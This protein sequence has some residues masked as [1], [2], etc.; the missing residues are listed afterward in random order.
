MSERLFQVLEI[1]GPVFALIGLG[2]LLH[3]KKWLTDEACHTINRI[4]ANLSLPALI[5]LVIARTDFAKLLKWPVIVGGLAPILVA[6]L[7]YLP[8]SFL[9]KIKG[10]ER[11]PFLYAPFWGNVSY[12]GIP[13]AIFAFGEAIGG[14]NAAIVNAFTMPFYV[15]I[16]T[17]IIGIHH[18]DKAGSLFAR[19]FGA[20]WNP[21]PLSAVAGI[22]V[23][24]SIGRFSLDSRMP[25]AVTSLVS[26]SA[27]TLELVGKMGLPLALLSI[28]AALR[29]NTSLRRIMVVGVGCFGRLVIAPLVALLA[30]KTFFPEAS[31][32]DVG[33]CVLVMATPVAVASYVISAK[34]EVAEELAGELVVSSTLMSV[35]SIP[36]WTYIC[37]GLSKTV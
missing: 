35:I 2:K 13:L 33:S 17:L 9:L 28:G 5:F 37:L 31:G 18:K 26:M 23:S 14:V 7:L 1:T 10:E 20:V 12:M 27:K 11:A 24:L 21:I 19:I 15:I 22:L 6:P 30:M 32:A 29:I 34:S 36:I 8:L 4:I 25:M 3:V 16:G